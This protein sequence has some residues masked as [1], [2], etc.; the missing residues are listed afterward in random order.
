MDGIVIPSS[1]WNGEKI[2]RIEQFGL[3][4]ATHVTETALHDLLSNG[5]SNLAYKEVGY[6]E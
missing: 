2:F 3:S 5:F 4:E 1:E 6:I